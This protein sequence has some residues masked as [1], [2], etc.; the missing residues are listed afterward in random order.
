MISILALANILGYYIFHLVCSRER[1]L[2]QHLICLYDREGISHAFASLLFFFC[3]IIHFIWWAI[4]KDPSNRLMVVFWWLDIPVFLCWWRSTDSRTPDFV[5]RS[6]W[7]KVFS[8]IAWDDNPYLVVSRIVCDVFFLFLNVPF[9][10]DEGIYFISRSYFHCRRC[11]VRWLGGVR[12]GLM[13]RYLFGWIA[14]RRTLELVGNWQLLV[15]SIL[16]FYRARSWAFSFLFGT[17]LRMGTHT[18][19]I[20]IWRSNASW[21]VLR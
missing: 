3:F 11:R 20:G 4:M 10:W 5:V 17:G 21:P 12:A 19:N 2:E 9:R 15:F 13:E 18:L 7:R 8:M 1:S 14:T 16:R 6:R